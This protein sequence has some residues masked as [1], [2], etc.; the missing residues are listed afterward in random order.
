MGGK[1]RHTPALTPRAREMRKHMTRQ[2]KR[3]WYDYLRNYP[4][5]FLRQKVIGGYIA[6]FYC[7]AAGLVIEADGFQHGE[8]Q[9]REY[10]EERTDLFK[11]Y[12]LTVMRF[13]N[14]HI[15]NCFFDVC[16]LIDRTVKKLMTE[17]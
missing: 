5:K 8:A 11:R 15:D 10:D 17:P 3:L 12:G 1:Y 9:N 7:A 4:V 2:E 13:S 16:E 14:Y 6:D